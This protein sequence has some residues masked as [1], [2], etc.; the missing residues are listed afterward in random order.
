M[1]TSTFAAV[2]SASFLAC[3]VTTIGIYVISKIRTVG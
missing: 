3:L 2:I 1:F